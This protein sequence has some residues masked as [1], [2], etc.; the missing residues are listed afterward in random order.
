[1]VS[2]PP[3]VVSSSSVVVSSSSDVDDAVDEPSRLTGFFEAL[4]GADVAVGSVVYVSAVVVSTLSSLRGAGAAD[5][6]RVLASAATVANTVETTSA[7][8]PSETY[9]ERESL[10]FSS[11]L[12]G[13]GVSSSSGSDMQGQPPR[14]VRR[15]SRRS[16]TAE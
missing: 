7:A 10:D 2:P 14:L 4:P 16:I 15:C 1:V 6:S 8:T 9:G 3:V 12:S 11:G 5:S 13:K